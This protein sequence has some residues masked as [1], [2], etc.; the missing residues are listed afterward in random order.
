MAL[1]PYKGFMLGIGQSGDLELDQ[2]DPHA[3]FA[4][5][6][7]KELRLGSSFDWHVDGGK[8]LTIRCRGEILAK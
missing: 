6:D 4:S 5:T 8:G 1:P 2:K 7:I 3:I